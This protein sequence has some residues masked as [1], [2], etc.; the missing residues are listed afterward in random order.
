M[1]TR[2]KIEY[3]LK[4][5]DRSNYKI[6]ISITNVICE[7]NKTQRILFRRNK[8]D[9]L[10]ATLLGY[11]EEGMRNSHPALMFPYPRFRPQN[12]FWPPL[13]A[14]LWL[15]AKLGFGATLNVRKKKYTI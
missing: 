12:S 2:L 11:S 9:V 4:H 10:N 1:Q 5:I 3:I 13:D 6:N 14:E 15:T 8:I 7:S